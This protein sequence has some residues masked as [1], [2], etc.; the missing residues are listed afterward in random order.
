MNPHLDN[1][2]KQGY[3]K[4]GYFKSA[5]LVGTSTDIAKSY[6]TEES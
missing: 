1:A 3:V 6:T 2:K 5:K 4:T